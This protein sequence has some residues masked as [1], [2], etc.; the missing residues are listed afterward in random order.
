METLLVFLATWTMIDAIFVVPQGKPRRISS[1]KHHYF[2]LR[3]RLRF[4]RTCGIDPQCLKVD[5]GEFTF[6][7]DRESN[8]A[9]FDLE[10]RV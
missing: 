2:G 1:S 10:L 4:R 6:V 3:S 8:V 7:I 5:L 9:V